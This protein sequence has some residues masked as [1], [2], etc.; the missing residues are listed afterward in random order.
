[1]IKINFS[2]E[3]NIII[4]KVINFN[5]IDIKYVAAFLVKCAGRL[6]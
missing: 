5:L 2:N 6:Q 3:R 4:F 1:M